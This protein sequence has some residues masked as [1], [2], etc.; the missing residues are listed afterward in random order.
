M[1]FGRGEGEGDGWW[2][3][4]IWGGGGGGKRPG[5]EEWNGL[6]ESF[7]LPFGVLS[8]KS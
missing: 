4:L 1:L 3:G 2:E 6:G 5:S 7:G 8:M